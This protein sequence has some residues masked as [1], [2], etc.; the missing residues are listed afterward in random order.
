[1]Q[2]EEMI[3]QTNMRNVRKTSRASCGLPEAPADDGWQQALMDRHF[4]GA[5]HV[6]FFVAECV[7]FVIDV[8]LYV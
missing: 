1:M 7:S 4:K 6:V 5:S 8:W 3:Q 2:S